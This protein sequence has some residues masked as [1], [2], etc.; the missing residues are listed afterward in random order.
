M[1]VAGAGSDLNTPPA[2]SIDGLLSLRAGRWCFVIDLRAKGSI[3]ANGKWYRGRRKGH[4]GLAEA[5][6]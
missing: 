1:P 6:I 3:R 4:S 5:G 2:A